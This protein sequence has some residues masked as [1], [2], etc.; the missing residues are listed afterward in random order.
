MHMYGSSWY[1]HEDR[2]AH[3]PE[4]IQ[5]TKCYMARKQFPCSCMS[6]PHRDQSIFAWLKLYD[7]LLIQSVPKICVN[8]ASELNR[9]TRIEIWNGN[10]P[11]KASSA[12]LSWIPGAQWAHPTGNKTVERNE[13][14][15]CVKKLNA[16]VHCLVLR[17]VRT[18]ILVVGH[19]YI[20]LLKWKLLWTKP[21][22]AC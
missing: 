18:R 16:G 14:R 8:Q 6:P 10:W 19:I 17:K 7:R 12:F 13:Y 11:G 4:P 5:A 9:L 21:P 3:R 2:A 22:Q 1:L 15:F 20:S